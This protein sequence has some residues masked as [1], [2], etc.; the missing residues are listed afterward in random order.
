[1]HHFPEQAAKAT[2]LENPE[3]LLAEDLAWLIEHI[4]M[5]EIKTR[6]NLMTRHPQPIGNTIQSMNRAHGG[7]HRWTNSHAEI[8]AGFEQPFQHDEWEPL[9]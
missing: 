6:P 7:V 1:M 8:F 4:F 9:D 3:A 5:C 2:I